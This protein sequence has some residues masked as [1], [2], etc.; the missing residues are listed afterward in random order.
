MKRTLLPGAALLAAICTAQPRLEFTPTELDAGGRKIPAERGWL[1]VPENRSKP[2]SQTLELHVLRIRTSNPNPQ[3]PVTYLAG[4]PGGAATSEFQMY[5]RLFQ[6]LLE[7]RDVVVMDQRGTGRSRP[8]VLWAAPA[9]LPPDAFES[10]A[11]LDGYRRAASAQALAAFRQ[12][13][14]DLAGYTSVE[15][16]DDLNDLRVALGA[17]K[18]ALVGFSYGTHLALATIRRHGPHLDAAVLIGTE[19]PDHTMKLPWVYDAQLRKISDLAAQ[20]PGV[21]EAVPD[22]VALLRRVL[23]KLEKEPVT[24]PVRDQRTKETVPLRIGK[25]GLQLLL[26]LDVGDRSDFVEFPALLHAI[27]RGD[28]KLLAKYAEKRYNQLGRGVSGMATMMDFASGATAERRARIARETPGSLLGAAVNFGDDGADPAWGNPDLGDAYRGPL[29]SSVRVL[30]V[31]GTMDSN[32]PPSQAEELRWGFANSGHVIVEYAGHEQT[33]PNL[34]VEAHILDFFAGKE[35]GT[36]GVSLGR[37]KFVPVA[38]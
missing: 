18:L 16:A 20:D 9:S 24:V 25:F 7:T 37:P 34:Q 29:L 26:R 4:G 8:S 13:G 27:D 32:T 22:M 38:K 14:I 19:G 1:K 12:R 5:G 35:I 15:S 33:L 3:P 21:R 28:Y 31:S 11:K 23:E 2:G 36:A 6:K 10:A 30:F 17:E